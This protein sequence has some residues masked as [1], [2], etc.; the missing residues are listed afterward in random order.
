MVSQPAVGQHMEPQL[1]ALTSWEQQRFVALKIKSKSWKK[2]RFVYVE[3][4]LVSCK[5]RQ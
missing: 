2:E 4:A 3:L 5:M 1:V